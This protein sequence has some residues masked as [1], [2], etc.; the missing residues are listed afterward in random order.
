MTISRALAQ[1]ILAQIILALSLSVTPA[2]AQQSD[3]DDSQG[4]DTA[5]KMTVDRLH[6]IIVRIDK[7]AVGDNGVWQL[8]V[9]DFPVTVVTDATNDRMRIVVPVARIE[10]L[11][12]RDLLR[13]MQANFDSA[14]DA[15]YAI[16][17]E[18]LWSTFI[19]PL[20]ALEDEEFLSALGQTV[21]LV[22]TFGST[23][24]SGAL[25]FGGGDS[26]GLIER[27]LIDELIRRGKAA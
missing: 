25:F 3:G 5:G 14:L 20:A 8:R 4:N 24:S 12:E 9:E 23:Y 15:R 11:S 6:E 27:K 22:V 21:N 16:G 10:G 7:D 2:L 19:H 1:I 18:I 13:V 26:Q 17:Q